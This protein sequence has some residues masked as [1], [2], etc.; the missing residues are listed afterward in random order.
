M[1]TTAV[2]R[3]RIALFEKQGIPIPEGW[4]LG[5]DGLPTTDAGAAMVG[6]LMPMA[7]PKGYGLALVIDL[8][9]GLLPGA[10][11]GVGM[12]GPLADDMSRPTG[13]GALF[14]AIA[15]DAFM[16]PADFRAR[17]DEALAALRATPRSPGVEHIRIPG[18]AGPTI[19]AQRRRDGIPLPDA[20]VR[21]FEDLGREADIPMPA[22]RPTPP[23]RESGT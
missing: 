21:E 7:G 4:A 22:P 2:A 8:L 9:A 11:F 1:A 16:D 6:T 5:P 15:I 14:G 10:L 18:D 19:I 23:V 17:M 12:G 20:I 13:G 3:G